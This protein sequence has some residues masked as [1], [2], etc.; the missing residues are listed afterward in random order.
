MIDLDKIKEETE[1]E[2]IIHADEKGKVINFINTDYSNNLALMSETV[3]SMCKDLLEDITGSELTQ[4]IARSTIDY[5]IVNKV[6]KNNIVLITSNN[7]SRFGLLLKYMNSI[8][9]Q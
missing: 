6:D 4:L 8:R 7:L 9:T 1:A 5:I 2:I 3:L